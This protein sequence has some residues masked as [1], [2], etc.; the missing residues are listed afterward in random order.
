MYYLKVLD[1]DT[2]KQICDISIST[3]VYAYLESQLKEIPKEKDEAENYYLCFSGI[4]EKG[5]YSYKCRLMDSRLLVLE[6]IT[7]K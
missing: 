4:M 5:K 3:H 7:P 1:Q 6:K 2:K